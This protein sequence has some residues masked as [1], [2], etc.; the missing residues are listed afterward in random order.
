MAVTVCPAMLLLFGLQSE[1][2]RK[3]NPKGSRGKRGSRP[4]RLVHK[5]G[6]G[7]DPSPRA[8]SPRWAGMRMKAVKARHVNRIS[9]G[10]GL[11]FTVGSTEGV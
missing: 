11:P 6:F 10:V 7:G 8:I 1:C 4:A 3:S 5:W 2:G 9:K